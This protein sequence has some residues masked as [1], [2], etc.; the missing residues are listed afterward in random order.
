MLLLRGDSPE[1]FSELWSVLPSHSSKSKTMQGNRLQVCL[2]FAA[3]GG[4]SYIAPSPLLLG[5]L[6]ML[7]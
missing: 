2:R 5:E 7:L 6:W 1:S 4:T 3:V